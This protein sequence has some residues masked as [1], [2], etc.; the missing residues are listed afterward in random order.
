MT[1]DYGVRS[2]GFGKTAAGSG[3][4]PVGGPDLTIG[5]SGD[6]VFD[7]AE[8]FPLGLAFGCTD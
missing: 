8:A 4:I 7:F 3:G 2:G 1:C 6:T 5:T